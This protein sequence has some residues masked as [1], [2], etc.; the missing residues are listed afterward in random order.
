MLNT[1]LC[2]RLGISHPILSA[3]IGAAATPELVAAVSNAG[4]LGVLGTASLP[5]KYVRQQI[6]RT[7]TLTGRPFGVNV[8]LP[9]LRRGQLEACFEERVPVLVLFWGEAA[10][11]L[12]AAR[13]A[14]TKVFVQVGSVAEAVSAARAGVD[15]VIA[16]GVEAGGHVRGST[17]LSVLVPAVVDAIHPVPVIAAGGIADGRGLVAALALGAQAVSMGTR[18]LASVEANAATA[19]KERVVASSA[20]DTVHTELFDGGWRAPHRVLRNRAVRAWEAAD[21]PDPG[22]RPDEGRVI[23]SMK[24]GDADVE[25]AAYS[26]YLPEADTTVDVDD[27]AMYAGQCCELVRAI[28]PAA[29]IVQSTIAQAKRILGQ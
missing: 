1:S 14:G 25:V 21:R 10:P 27:M 12:E 8:V 17:A 15:G 4:G 16:Q 28:L 13:A 24:S 22:A 9:L 11:Y 20:A 2:S 19:Y 18:F 7:R 29:T 3:G 23:G 5:G 26:A 6:V